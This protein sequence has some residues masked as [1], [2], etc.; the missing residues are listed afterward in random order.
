MAFLIRL[1]CCITI[2]GLTLLAIVS[3]HNMLTEARMRLPLLAKQL[4]AVEEENV[5]LKFQIEKFENPL[6][7]MLLARKPEYSHL[8]H[9]L[10][11]DVITVDIPKQDVHSAP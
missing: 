9:P 8:K 10:M 1:F 5:R 2:L 11:P 7:L 3:K 4:Q 6:H